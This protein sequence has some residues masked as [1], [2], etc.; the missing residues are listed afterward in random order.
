VGGGGEGLGG[1]AR[2]GPWEAAGGGRAVAL[3]F[4][5][6]R[7]PDGWREGGGASNPGW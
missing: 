1:G 2:V 5:S 3:T 4:S 7:R 6:R